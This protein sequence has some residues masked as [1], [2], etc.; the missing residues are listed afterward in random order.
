MAPTVAAVQVV[1]I[2]WVALAALAPHPRSMRAAR[3]PTAVAVVVAL[4]M[5]LQQ[6]LVQ[7]VAV[8]QVLA[9]VLVPPRVQISA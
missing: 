2:L 7:R 8:L 3:T 1:L 4:V 5:V 9:Q 6:V